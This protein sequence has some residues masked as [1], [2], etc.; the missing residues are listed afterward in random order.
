VSKGIAYMPVGWSRQHEIS[1][2]FFGQHSISKEQI[3]Y[4]WNL[5]FN[6]SEL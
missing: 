2:C 5:L 4:F 3:V 1:A 6:I